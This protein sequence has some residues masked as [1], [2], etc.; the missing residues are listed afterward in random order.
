MLASMMTQSGKGAMVKFTQASTFDGATIAIPICM[1][2]HSPLTSII[3]ARLSAGGPGVT[4]SLC[5][6]SSA[7]CCSSPRS[8]PCRTRCRTGHS[9]EGAAGVG[10]A[11]AALSNTELRAETSSCAFRRHRCRLFCGRCGHLWLLNWLVFCPRERL[12]LRWPARPLP[13]ICAMCLKGRW[14]CCPCGR[15]CGT[16]VN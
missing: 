5:I 3:D 15:Q 1:M 8:A 13:C 12:M 9:P 7:F 10:G 6:P 14:Q 11:A 2:Y 4:F 16:R